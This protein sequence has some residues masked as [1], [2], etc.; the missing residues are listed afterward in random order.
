MHLV[1]LTFDDALPCHLDSVVPL[2]NQHGFKGTFYVPFTSSC[3]LDRWEEWQAISKVGHE[4]GNHTIFHPAVPEKDWVDDGNSIA[5]YTLE[6]MARELDIANQLLRRLDGETRRTFAYPCSNSVLGSPG[7]LE[8]L[9]QILALSRTRIAPWIRKVP[10]PTDNRRDYSCL[11]DGRFVAARSGASDQFTNRW[12]TPCISG[13]ASSAERLISDLE[14]HRRHQ[15]W[16]VFTFHHIGQGPS[17]LTIER[18]EFEEFL[19][20][21]ARRQEIEV[22]TFMKA[23]NRFWDLNN[24]PRT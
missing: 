5:R 4:L 22:C 23:S 8:R 16:T 18:H 10:D 17:Q 6:R 13:D 11:L 21:L 15:K 9:L 1:S 24:R 20:E 3:L 12:K 7:I 19:T 14:S 2:L